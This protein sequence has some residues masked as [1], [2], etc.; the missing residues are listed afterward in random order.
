MSNLPVNVSQPP[1]LWPLMLGFMSGVLGYWLALWSSMP[2]DEAITRYSIR[3]SLCWYFAALTLM[4]FA[5]SGDWTFKTHL[6]HWLRWCWS[7]AALIFAIHVALAFHYYH[8]W[9]HTDAWQRT[10]EISGFGNGLYISYLFTL[11]WMLDAILWWL[12]PTWIAR[13]PHWIQVSLNAIML[14]IVF[15]G[16]VIFAS[17]PIRIVGLVV[18]ISIPIVWWLGRWQRLPVMVDPT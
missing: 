7:W 14:F 5:N 18:F 13:R 4:A 17:G 11:V 6:G 1:V 2:W 12:K 9:S 16:M 3:V 8:A 10:Q 15:N